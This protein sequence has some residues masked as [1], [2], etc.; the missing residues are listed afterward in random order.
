VYRLGGL[1]RRERPFFSREV[2]STESYAGGALHRVH[3]GLGRLRTVEVE[4]IAPWTGQRRV[5]RGVHPGRT[6]R[7][8][9]PG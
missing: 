4:V 3:V 8:H 1:G 5:V 9:L 7:V 2:S 6:V